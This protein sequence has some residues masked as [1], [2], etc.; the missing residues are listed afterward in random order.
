[1]PGDIKPTKGPRIG[2]FVPFR[3][4]NG[5]VKPPEKVD[6]DTSGLYKKV[7]Q[8][9]DL[10]SIKQLGGVVNAI[11]GERPLAPAGQGKSDLESIA[12]IAKMLGIDISKMTESREKEVEAL[13]NERDQ[14]QREIH[15]MRLQAYDRA[16]TDMNTKMNDFVKEMKGGSNQPQGL[17]G[18]A[19]QLLG[20]GLSKQVIEKGLGWNQPTAPVRDSLDELID[21][22]AKVEKVRSALGLH[23]EDRSSITAAALQTAKVDVIKALLE[24]DRQRAA[25]DQANS[26]AKMKVDRL[27]G[28]LDTITN[29]L[30]DVIEAWGASR[31]EG[32]AAAAAAASG[33]VKEKVKEGQQKRIAQ[34]T[35]QT[36]SQDKGAGAAKASAAPQ[37]DPADPS[38][39]T[40]TPILCPHPDCGKEI[41][42]PNEIPAEMAWTCPY[43]KK[44]I[45]KAPAAPQQAEGEIKSQGGRID[46]K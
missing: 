6:I 45:Q 46:G 29:A 26:L 8:M 10:A 12:S 19:D 18:L 35:A 28:F 3:G 17:F 1:M 30:P 16:M 5:E 14:T 9:I 40:Y 32:A 33:R 37:G 38:T 34:E 20:N 24:D 21:S 27:G 11:T 44:P 41:P 13:R 31:G 39:W 22:L 42:F 23:Q 25:L 43:C 7:D 4:Q 36:Q 2:N 15:E